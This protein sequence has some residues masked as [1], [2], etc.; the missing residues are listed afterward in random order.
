MSSSNLS[1]QAVDGTSHPPITVCHFA[2]CCV[3]R[4]W[5]YNILHHNAAWSNNIS[6]LTCNSILIQNNIFY[7]EHYVHVYMRSDGLCGCVTCDSEYTVRV[8]FSILTNILEDF[9]IQNPTWKQGKK[10]N[11]NI[12]KIKRIVGDC[13]RVEIS[14]SILLFLVCATLR[15]HI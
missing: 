14:D 1:L 4:R 12:R 7:T 5:L 11:M 6:H 8:A 3:F 15:V 2:L 9:A 10:K 13:W